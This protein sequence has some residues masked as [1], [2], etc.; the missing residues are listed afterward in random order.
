MPV[1]IIY[2]RATY[3]SK[4]AI[5]APVQPILGGIASVAPFLPLCT[6]SHQRKNE[7]R[8]DSSDSERLFVWMRCYM[9]NSNLIEAKCTP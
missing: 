9:A 4:Q 7:Y 1:A 5:I 3:R 2:K 8:V 6:D